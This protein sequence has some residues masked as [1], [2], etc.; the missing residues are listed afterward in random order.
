M[1]VAVITVDEAYLRWAPALV[2]GLAT[3]ASGVDGMAVVVPAG[4][5]P[6]AW[7][8]TADA[9]RRHGLDLEVRTL[10]GLDDLDDRTRFP[11]TDGP[12]SFA[13]ARLAM[14]STLPDVDRVLYLDVDILV[15]G[16]LDVLLDWPLRRT[17]AMAPELTAQGE[18]LFGD[19]RVPYYN[20]GV[21][22]ASLDRW[23]ADD[24]LGRSLDLLATTPGLRFMDQDVLNVLLRGD[25][26]PLPITFNVPDSWSPL[27]AR[28]P[29]LR[30]PAIVH[31]SGHPKPWVAE[32]QAPHARE[33]RAAFAAAT[34]RPLVPPGRGGSSRAAGVVATLRHS[35]AG[36]AV[37]RLL[38]VGV[39]DSVKRAVRGRA[40]GQG[41]LSRGVMVGLQSSQRPD[42]R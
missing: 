16:P 28:V 37:R 35:S 2:R 19:I 4:T 31:F 5:S 26:D 9:A 29:V 39:K 11:L 15:R 3:H 1:T 42:G 32:Y 27:A 23:R 14:G 12:S 7:Q 8:D 25:I 21:L 17:A 34:G 40:G 36:R 18:R 22:V 30:D 41:S 13:Y 6:R 38:P 10:V 33:W 20:S 24:V